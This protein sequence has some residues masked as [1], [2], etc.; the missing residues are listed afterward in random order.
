MPWKLDGTFERINPDFFGPT[1]WSQDQVASIKVIAS[2][3]DYHD[4]DLA[5]GIAGSLS[6][7][8]YNAMRADLDMGGNAIINVLTGTGPGELGL[9]DNDIA[10]GE[11]ETVSRELTLITNDGTELPAILIPDSGGGSGSTNLGNT[12]SATDVEI[13]SSSGTPTT[14]A[15]AVAGG[16]AGV[17]TGA[18]AQQLLDLVNAAAGVGMIPPIEIIGINPTPQNN[19]GAL[20]D[21]WTARYTATV[22]EVWVDLLYIQGSGLIEFLAAVQVSLSP[23]S[24][25]NIRM[26]IDEEDN[27]TPVWE[28][29]GPFSD[30]GTQDDSGICIIGVVDTG[31]SELQNLQQVKFNKSMRIQVDGN[32]AN[33]STMAAN[34]KWQKYS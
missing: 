25:I 18:Q 11:F 5:Q 29:T 19:L 7:D 30:A 16:N 24:T 1:V 17:M 4:E 27:P 28:E 10:R 26:Y 9:W 33:A 8:G 22:R 12:P 32:Q 31:S 13:T 21:A 14:I 15:A 23:S 2:R 34:I 20:V 6:L 3:H